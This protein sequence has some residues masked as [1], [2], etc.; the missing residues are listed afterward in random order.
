MIF[1]L[2]LALIIAAVWVVIALAFYI[3]QPLFI[4]R[5]KSERTDPASLG[6]DHMTEH[7]IDT[8]DG[9][10]LVAWFAPAEAGKPTILYFHGN[11]G[12]L[13]QRRERIH[14]YTRKGYGLLMPSYRGYSGSTGK[15][16]EAWLICDGLT[17]YDYLRNLGVESSSIVVYGESIGTGVAT[18]VAVSRDVAALMLEAPFTSVVDVA[19]KKYPMFPVRTFIEHRFESLKV[20][21]RLRAPLFVIH[22]AKDKVIPVELGKELFEAAPK[23]KE[24]V[25]IEDAG[26]QY[27][28][29]LGGWKHIC[30]FLERKT[31]KTN[32]VSAKVTKL[33]RTAAQ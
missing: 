1:Y 33:H 6:L 14:R 30:D 19:A 32:P 24:M 18:P 2:E 4:F 26:H 10:K 20:I 12:D 23:D 8:P 28:Y 9:Q 7:E 11:S 27:L 21:N 25:V 3:C 13:S 31:H 17:A 22:G 15:P 16:S 5:P 29:R